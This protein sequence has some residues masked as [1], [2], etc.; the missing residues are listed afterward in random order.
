LRKADGFKGLVDLLEAEEKN[1][2]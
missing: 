2:I 1:D